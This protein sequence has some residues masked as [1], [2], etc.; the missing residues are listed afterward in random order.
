MHATPV[1]VLEHSLQETVGEHYY[2]D[3][4]VVEGGLLSGFYKLHTKVVPRHVGQ[5]SYFMM[6]YLDKG[7]QA[8]KIQKHVPDSGITRNKF[9]DACVQS[10]QLESLLLFLGPDYGC[11]LSGVL[12]DQS[13]K[14][15]LS[16]LIFTV[17]KLDLDN[18]LSGNSLKD[19]F[20]SR[21]IV[22]VAL[23]D[24]KLLTLRKVHIQLVFEGRELG[25]VRVFN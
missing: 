1:E 8:C 15:L 5:S 3:E 18:N 10:M 23:F 9:G 12:L 14:L 25:A 11:R 22:L 6:I 21:E 4:Q 19:L 13:Y 7:K 17:F 16:S 24:L 2:H 20:Q